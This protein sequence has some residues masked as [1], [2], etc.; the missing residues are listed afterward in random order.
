MHSARIVG[1]SVLFLFSLVFFCSSSVVAQEYRW[2]N[3]SQQEYVENLVACRLELK[4]FEWSKTL[5]P[6]S[7]EQAKPSFDSVMSVD[8]VR[9][10]VHASLQQQATLAQRFGVSIEPAMLQNDLDRMVRDTRD[11]ATL[12]AMFALFENDATT[13]AHCVSRPFLVETRLANALNAELH[14]ATPGPDSAETPSTISLADTRATDD[15]VFPIITDL[16]LPGFSDQMSGALNGIAPD[17][18]AARDPMPAERV[19]QTAVWTGTEMIVWGGAI[20]GIQLN[21]GGRYNPAT[22]SWRE[23]SMTGAPSAR[24]KHTAVWTGTEM[25][26]WGG[27]YLFNGWNYLRDGGRYDPVSDTWATTSVSGAPSRRGYHTAVWT[28]EELLIWGGWDGIAYLDTGNRYNP[29]SDSWQVISTTNSPSERRHH[30]AVWTGEEMIVWGGANLVNLRSGKRY[31]PDLDQ[32]QTMTEDDSPIWRWA[33]SAVWTGEAMIVW[34]GASGNSRYNTGGVYSPAT[35]TWQATSL[36]NAPVGRIRHS[37]IWTGTEMVVWAGHDPENFRDGGRYNPVSNNWSSLVTSNAP[38]ARHGHSTVWTGS[39]MIVWGGLAEGYVS[40]GSRFDPV[41]NIWQPTD[42]TDSARARSYH[43]TVWTGMDMIVWGGQHSEYL[44]D[45]GR[46]RPATDSWSPLS[47]VN[48]PSPRS[49]HTAVW[50]GTEMMVWG[51]KSNSPPIGF[52]YYADGARYRPLNDLWLSVSSVQA[53]TARYDHTAVWTGTEMIVWAGRGDIYENSGAR[54][55]PQANAWSPISAAS[56]LEGR[57]RHTAVWT[58]DEMIVWGGWSSDGG[59]TFYNNGARYNPSTD[60]WQGISSV[61]APTARRYHSAIWT[62][63]EMIIWGGGPNGAGNM[64]QTGGRYNLTSD[65]WTATSTASA[66]SRRVSHT[67][68]W[69]GQ[70]MIVWGGIF[71]DGFQEYFDSG[72]VYNPVT[73]AWTPTSLINV[74]RGRMN[75]SAVWTGESMLIWGGNSGSSGGSSTQSSGVYYP[76]ETVS[77]SIFRDRFE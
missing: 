41:T 1:V 57:S 43:S 3:I 73:N 76:Y 52:T 36:D 9:R 23:V 64:T 77:D 12:A 10:S 63:D 49:E 72:G 21:T 24:E 4:Q 38:S 35:D 26:I 13:I 42:A 54:Y 53:P 60:N 30:T 45:G 68:V 62:G 56:G 33:H 7:N 2:T 59:S 61:S 22:D 58:G 48:A 44:N 34:G 11:A 40:T 32:W 37:A 46:Y 15:Y 8:E 14:S 31:D 51:G 6:D 47:T 50:T 19:E 75:H 74:P 55:D 67:A 71:S 65:T 28:G 39:Q 70:D 29:A 5:W 18:W 69:T 25:V 20:G 27:R 66:P 17:T 16:S